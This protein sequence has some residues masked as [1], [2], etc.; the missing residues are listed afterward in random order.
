[1]NKQV[2]SYQGLKVS[3]SRLED[4]DQGPNL[5]LCTKNFESSVF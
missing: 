4:S 3:L 1:M 5:V 2:E